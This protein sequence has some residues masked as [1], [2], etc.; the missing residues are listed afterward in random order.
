MMKLLLITVLFFNSFNINCSSAKR[1]LDGIKVDSLPRVEVVNK[2]FSN[3]L[4]EV[5]KHEKRCN[6]YNQDLMFIIHFQNIDLIETIQIESTHKVMKLGNELA[7]FTMNDHFFLILGNELD[8]SIVKKTTSKIKV[9]FLD[10]FEES[11]ESGEV[12]LEVIEDD[13]YS[14][15][16]LEN[17]K[18]FDI[19]K[20]YS[21]CD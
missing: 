21:Y 18:N 4:E 19:I 10:S 7:G 15:W 20:S 1:P 16:L 6:Y 2:V 5:I 9:K 13:S 3:F 12:V 11:N 17:N 8:E 14:V